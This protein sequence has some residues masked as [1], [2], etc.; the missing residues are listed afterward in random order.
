MR[1]N[2][3]ALLRR[4]TGASPASRIRRSQQRPLRRARLEGQQ[5][6]LVRVRHAAHGVGNQLLTGAD[7]GIQCHGN[8]GHAGEAAPEFFRHVAACQR[9]Q[10]G[11]GPV[12]ADQV[13]DK[14]SAQPLVDAFARQQLAGVEQVARTQAWDITVKG[15]SVGSAR[16]AKAALVLTIRRRRE[17]LARKAGQGWP[18]AALRSLDDGVD[19]IETIA[20]LIEQE[21]SDILWELIPRDD[22]LPPSTPGPSHPQMGRLHQPRQRGQGR[23]RPAPGAGPTGARP[24]GQPAV[25]H[26]APAASFAQRRSARRR[27]MR[28]WA[29]SEPSCHVP[30][31]TSKI[32]RP[33]PPP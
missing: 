10:L 30:N 17:D 6:A 33:S 1:R 19:R 9:Q 18:D 20:D 31:R 13:D 26:A 14:G 22:A 29:S 4:S 25:L 24:A 7:K 28:R 15:I 3:Q 12:V 21:P 5:E 32:I 23:L 27:V 11:Q 2:R 16:Y 8:L